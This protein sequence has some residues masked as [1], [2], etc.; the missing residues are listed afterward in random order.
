LVRDQEADIC[1]LLSV[2]KMRFFFYLVT[3]LSFQFNLTVVSVVFCTNFIVADRQL[4]RRVIYRDVPRLLI[5]HK[6]TAKM[7]LTV[8]KNMLKNIHGLLGLV[9][10]SQRVQIKAKAEGEPGPSH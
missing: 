9:S 3:P 10:P 1:M 2:L 6:F 5:N 7:K 8:Y 4:F